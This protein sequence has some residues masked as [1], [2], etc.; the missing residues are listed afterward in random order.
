MKLVLLEYTSGIRE[1]ADGKIL[2]NWEENSILGSKFN[3]F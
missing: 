1:S 3:L 2:L